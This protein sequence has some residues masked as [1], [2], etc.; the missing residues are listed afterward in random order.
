[1]S[2]SKTD[3]LELHGW[4]NDKSYCD[5]ARYISLLEEK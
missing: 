5:Y 3:K 1:M 4:T 2:K